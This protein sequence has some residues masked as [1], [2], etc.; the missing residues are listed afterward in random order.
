SEAFMKLISIIML[1]APIGLG[2]YF[3]ALIGDYGSEIIGAYGKAIIMFFPICIVYFFIAFAG[4]AYFAGGIDGIKIFFKNIFPSAVT[5]LAT[6]SSI[7]TLP[8]NFAATKRMGVSED[9]S[10][11]IL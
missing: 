9:I 3:A 10:S 1:Y 5:S 4:Y 7:A 8:T 11:I 2:A 6:Q